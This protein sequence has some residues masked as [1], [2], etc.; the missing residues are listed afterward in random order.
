[1]VSEHFKLTNPSGLHLRPAQAFINKI[2]PFSSSVY[3]KYAGKDL[4]AKSIIA[5]LVAGIPCG[6]NITVVCEGSDEYAALHAVR[7]MILSGFGENPAAMHAHHNK[8]AHTRTINNALQGIGISQGYAIG[9]A[10]WMEET[11]FDYSAKKHADADTQKARLSQAINRFCAETEQ[12]VKTLE[13]NCGA[14]Q[15]QILKGHIALL[16]D[17]KIRSAL[18]KKTDAGMLAEAAVDTVLQMWHD[19]LAQANDV[20]IR[21]RAADITDIKEQLLRLLL[22]K[23]NPAICALPK[24]CV[25]IAKEFTPSMFGKINKER[26]AAMIS[27]RGSIAQHSAILARAMGV[28]AV[29]SL[30]QAAKRIHTGDMLIVD[31]LHGTVICSPTHAQIKEYTEKQPAFV[32][33]QQNLTRFISHPAVTQSG[34][35][36]KVYGNIGKAEEAQ[37]VLANGGEG[38]GL[39]RSE[40]LF[41]DKEREPTQQEQFEAYAAVAKMMQGKEVIIRTMDIGADK[42]IPYLQPQ[43][44]SSA[45]S[46]DR[47]IRFS[48]QHKAI[49]QTQVRAI[50]TAAC[51]GNIKM[52]LPFIT[53]PEEIKQAKV[54]I[55][56]CADTLKNEGLSYRCIPVGVMIETPSAAM[57]SDLLAKEADFFSIGTND[58]IAYTMAVDRRDANRTPLYDVFQPAVLRAIEMTIKNAKKAG[59]PVGICAQAATNPALVSRLI[60]WGADTF[61]V[62]ATDILPL[63]KTIIEQNSYRT[64]SNR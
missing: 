57:I 46:G 43:K 25:L 1:M 17:P 15:A 26:I 54:W 40:F 56:Q 32:R 20:Y 28:P 27:E 62:S 37:D 9:T 48:L 21:Q 58:L 29:F 39:F 19:S 18:Y 14:K 5:L 8:S 44:Q 61:S 11:A 50:L 38:I 45:S 36:K 6:A 13:N 42:Y 34:I 30:S 59:I 33:T 16:G 3:I 53:C 35:I 52:L 23:N 4:I 7:S 63:K 47:G 31:G 49:F 24:G 51:Y 10:V 60:E 12:A 41:M 64:E 2:T 22:K 55:A